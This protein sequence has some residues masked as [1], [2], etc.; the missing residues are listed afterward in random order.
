MLERTTKT[1]GTATKINILQEDGFNLKGSRARG[2]AVN[3]M[4]NKT[5]GEK[6]TR[7]THWQIN[8]SL[9]N[10]RVH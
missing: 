1:K 10:D 6:R 2:I 5:P 7:N 3:T 8:G 9:R 4:N